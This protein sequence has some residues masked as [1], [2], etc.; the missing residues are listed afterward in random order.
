[1]VVEASTLYAVAHGYVST[2]YSYMQEDIVDCPGYSHRQT[3]ITSCRYRWTP[4]L[5][6]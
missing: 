3:A 2:S 5:R 4:P 1:M 6:T